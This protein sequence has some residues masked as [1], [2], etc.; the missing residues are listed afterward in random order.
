M[1]SLNEKTIAVIG[2][3]PVG[4]SAAV[5][6]KT[7]GLQPLVIDKGASVGHAMKEWG[8]VRVFTPWQYV[9]DKAV[10]ELLEKTGWE[11]PDKEH[12]PTGLE[13]VEQY[14][15]PAASLPELKDAIIYNAEVIAVSKQGRSKSSSHNRDEVSYTIHYK[16]VD[17]EH[18]IVEADGVVD[19]SGTWYNPNPIGADGLPV[20][21]EKESKEFIAYG[22]PNVLG[23][24]R[25]LY[26]GQR[27]LVLGSGHSA[28]NIV[29]DIL[30]LKEENADTKLIWGLR[31]NKLEKL[32]GG[33]VNDELPARGALGQN[34]DDPVA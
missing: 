7:R 28:I 1:E 9:T 6:L 22:V 19:A 4:I 15:K 18:H 29:L 13:I 31:Q 11:H 12:L 10:V 8:H 16:T 27:T 20:A 21:G 32:L 34:S 3:G 5:H 25:S 23:K 17:G 14:L 24:N 26:E 30:R 2:A 33:G